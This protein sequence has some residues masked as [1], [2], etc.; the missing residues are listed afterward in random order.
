MWAIG[1]AECAKQ[2][3]ID[4]AGHRSGVRAVALSGDDALML[5]AAEAS[6]KVWNPRSAACLRHI[7]TNHGLCV[8]FAPGEPLCCPYAPTAQP[9]IVSQPVSDELCVSSH[10][11]Q[12]HMA[13]RRYC[14]KSP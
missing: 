9:M 3:S 8:M 12:K 5:T 13:Q 6:V 14:L 1:E 4:A 2:L 7:D 10:V 11:L